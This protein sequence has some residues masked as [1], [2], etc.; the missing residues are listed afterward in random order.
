MLVIEKTAIDLIP[1]PTMLGAI[2]TVFAAVF[3]V[4]GG[5]YKPFI[6]LIQNNP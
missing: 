4:I 1:L 2:L 3:M 5:R 6:I